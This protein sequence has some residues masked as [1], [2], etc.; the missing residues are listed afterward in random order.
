MKKT[1]IDVKALVQ[2]FI[3]SE[4]RGMH[5]DDCE[6]YYND[7]AACA[8]E[9]AKEFRKYDWQL[10]SVKISDVETSTLSIVE[11]VNDYAAM[12]GEAPAIIVFKKKNKLVIKD[13]TH[14][15]LAAQAKGLSEIKAYVGIKKA[16]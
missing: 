5:V 13:G 12:Q 11:K 3:V 10:T 6:H 14:R 1:N 9:A 4:L 8:E 7:I 16:A 15:L 2:H